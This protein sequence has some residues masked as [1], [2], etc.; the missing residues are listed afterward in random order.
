MTDI[1]SVI[2]WMVLAGGT[3]STGLEEPRL[4]PQII[5]PDNPGAGQAP[6]PGLYTSEPWT[7]LVLVPG[8]HRDERMV[9][10][11]QDS[12]RFQMPIIE[13]ELRLVPRESRQR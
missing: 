3:P 4:D 11:A 5:L 7:C 8:P 2:A 6:E 13:P 1:L 9:R 10:G 12:R